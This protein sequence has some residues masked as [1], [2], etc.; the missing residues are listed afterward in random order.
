MTAALILFNTRL[1]LIE[2]IFLVNCDKELLISLKVVGNELSSLRNNF[3]ASLI[4][5]THPTGDDEI[6]KAKHR[7]E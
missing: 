7:F 5:P 2:K 4:K 3:A 1:F 6:V